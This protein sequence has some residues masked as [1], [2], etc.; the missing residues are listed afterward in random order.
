MFQGYRRPGSRW[1]RPCADQYR[2]SAR[3]S[4]Q[5]RR[6]RREHFPEEVMG[7][8]HPLLW[9][10]LHHLIAKCFVHAD[11][12]VAGAARPATLPHRLQLPRQRIGPLRDVAGAEAAPRSRPAARAL[13]PC[14]RA[15]PAPSSGDD[16]GGGRARAGPR[17]GCRGR[18]RRSAPRPPRRRAATITVSASL[19]QVQNWSNS[20]GEPRVAVRLHHGDHLA[21]VD[22]RAA[23]QHRGDLHR[24]V[25]VIVEDRRRRSTRRCG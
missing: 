6:R 24:M 16:A 19:K 2:L 8:L 12:I 22:S 10:Q 25:A 1:C 3:L 18:R 17:P 9:R 23:L 14:R 21:L 4:A 13:A 15:L 11:R 5:N 7:K 20:D